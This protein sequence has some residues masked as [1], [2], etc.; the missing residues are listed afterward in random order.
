M[1]GQAK[2]RV[3]RGDILFSEIR[4][5][6][7]R[8]AV[9]RGDAED[10]VVSTKLM[11]LRRRNETHSVLRL[12]HYLTSEAFIRELQQAA[13]GRSGTF[14]QITFEN[15]IEPKPFVVGDD[16]VENRW[17]SILNACI[18]QRFARKD[19]TKCLA[20]IADLLLRKLAAL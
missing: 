5:Q 8:Y 3:K 9:V 18:A 11:V 20:E 19:E 4:P 14:P 2:K 6:N 12:Y 7:R 15:D 17:N 16:T 13:E 1:P 10:Y